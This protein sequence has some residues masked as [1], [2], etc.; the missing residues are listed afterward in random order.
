MDE[1]TEA[2]WGPVEEKVDIW[3]DVGG[4]E[5]LKAEEEYEKRATPGER[6]RASNTRKANARITLKN[7][8]GERWE[9]EF[10]PDEGRIQDP[11]LQGLAAMGRK[12]WLEEVVRLGMDLAL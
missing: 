1:V 5:C 12:G 9:E 10:D 8:W 11:V 2:V 3:K 6:Y 4:E 7:R